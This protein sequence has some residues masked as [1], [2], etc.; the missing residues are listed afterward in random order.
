MYLAKMLD[1]CNKIGI[2]TSRI[3]FRQQL[4]EELA[5]YSSICF[6][7]ECQLDTLDAWL[8]CAG[9]AVRNDYDL[10]KHQ[11]ASGQSLTTS[12]P[13]K[14][15]IIEYTRKIAIKPKKLKKKLGAEKMKNFNQIKTEIENQVHSLDKNELDKTLVIDGIE[16]QLGQDIIV[17]DEKVTIQTEQFLP[18]VIEPSFGIS[19]LLQTVLEHCYRTRQADGRSFFTFPVSVAPIKCSVLTIRKCDQMS[20]IVDDIGSALQR[21]SISY[22]TDS[23]GT[24]IGRKYLKSDELGTP[25]VIVVDDDTL[26]HSSVTIRDRD[27]LF[28]VRVPLDRVNGKCIKNGL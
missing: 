6:D 9:L 19:R 26:R 7:L 13:L 27:T 16:L 12:R 25:F 22:E 3:R 24:I 10:I 21:L 5:H 23:S 4:N 14:E 18:H 1:F 20:G 2:D 11:N 8:E 15:P 28:Q 17:K